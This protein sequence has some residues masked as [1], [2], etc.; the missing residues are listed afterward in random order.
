MKR[1]PEGA[2]VTSDCGYGNRSDDMEL[3][4]PFGFSIRASGRAVVTAILVLC[5]IAALVWHDYKSTE[6]NTLMV[7]ALAVV[8]YVL[9]LDERERKALQLRMPEGLRKRL[10]DSERSIRK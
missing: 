6:Q 1:T 9:T 5:V 2:D 10:L 3:R 8:S 4:F 7:E